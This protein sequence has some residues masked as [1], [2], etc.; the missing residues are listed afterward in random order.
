[1]WPTGTKL[2]CDRSISS[3]L[4][5]DTRHSKIEQ[6]LQNADQRMEYEVEKMLL[7]QVP[8]CPLGAAVP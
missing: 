5:T 6:V 2:A 3:A 8:D 4:V 7:S 1:M